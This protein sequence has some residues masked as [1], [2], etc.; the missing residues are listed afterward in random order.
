MGYSLPI[1]RSGGSWPLGGI[2]DPSPG[3]APTRHRL[4]QSLGDPGGEFQWGRAG[5]H[6]SKNTP[7][8][9]FTSAGSSANFPTF[10]P[11]VRFGTWTRMG[12]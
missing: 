8:H 2:S 9:Q 7:A 10:R 3:T 1:P 11:F 5:A 12:G 6:A 4:T